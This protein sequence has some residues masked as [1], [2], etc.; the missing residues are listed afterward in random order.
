[1]ALFSFSTPGR[2][3]TVVQPPLTEPISKALKILGSTPLSIDAPPSNRDDASSSALSDD[4]S[5][6]TATSC[7]PDSEA[8]DFFDDHPVGIAKSD[9]GWGHDSDVLPHP[10]TLD[11]DFADGS[12]TSTSSI[13]RKSRSSSTIKSWY[14]RSK[15]PLSISQQTSS[16]A[17]AKG[18]PVKTDRMLDLDSLH[19]SPTEPRPTR[20]IINKRKPARLD[21]STLVSRP[22]PAPSQTLPQPLDTTS[23]LILGP[24]CIM[25][26]PS[27]LSPV[28][29]VA[30]KPQHKRHPERG[31]QTAHALAGSRPDAHGSRWPRPNDALNALPTLYDHYEQMSIRHVMR[32]Y[33]QPD[34][35]QPRPEPEAARPRPKKQRSSQLIRRG[36]R[37]LDWL[38]DSLPPTPQ[39]AVHARSQEKPPAAA[40]SAGALASRH[41]RD[42]KESKTADRSFGSADLRQTS[43]LLLSDSEGDENVDDFVPPRKSSVPATGRRPSNVGND[44]PPRVPTSRPSISDSLPKDGEQASSRSSKT[45]KRASFAL[46]HTYITIPSVDGN[47]SG[48]PSPAVSPQGTHFPSLG[49]NFAPAASDSQRRESL[50]S[51]YSASST[52]TGR[53]R[54][55]TY[56][57]REARAVTLKSACRLSPPEREKPEE[58][59]QQSV[60]WKQ[61][62]QRDSVSSST[63]Q[64]TPPLSPTSVDF[65]IRSARSSIDGPGSHNR[66]MAVTRQEEMLLSALRQ[67]QRAM[68]GSALAE[69]QK[70]TEQ[71]DGEEGTPKEVEIDGQDARK[72]SWASQRGASNER[73]SR[74]SQRTATEPGRV[75]LDFSAASSSKNDSGGWCERARPAARAYRRWSAAAIVTNSES[76]RHSQAS[77]GCGPSAEE[78]P[79][80]LDETEPSPDLSD[81]RD[82]H[83]ATT[84]NEATMA[85]RPTSRCDHA[86]SQGRA[87]HQSN[88][89]RPQSRSRSESLVR[90]SDVA[91]EASAATRD[92]A[93]I[94]RPDSPISPES[95]P[96][97][98]PGQKPRRNKARLSAVGPGV[99]TGSVALP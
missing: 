85:G 23:R 15:L 90:L 53:S 28:T 77:S 57:I 10:L 84:K 44:E 61:P 66:L 13:L 22:R 87:S 80:I 83:A 18:L 88:P 60:D 36:S 62:F 95:F 99:L 32:Q 38:H 35:S 56:S 65:F 30:R 59:Q 37:C 16:S 45:R 91:E 4:R 1:M 40:H 92:E 74:A 93:D 21:L 94:P 20:T 42:S 73:P 50:A 27:I 6:T 48:W 8:G 79:F 64:L 25:K 63:D 81:F 78:V 9:N 2:K 47:S 31:Q 39:T 3:K 7:G 29:P 82:W 67:K 46:A 11:V 96:S 52:T 24:D 86:D 97:V 58:A 5:I 51:N 54:K 89:S 98:P 72:A 76:R 71:D 75:G 19:S 17:M 41:T 49:V 12:A 14:D 43:V 34:I 26:S 33:S 55:S 68:R 70:K 69:L